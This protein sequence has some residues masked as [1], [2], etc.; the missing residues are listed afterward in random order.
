MP[1]LPE[2]ET[3]VLGLRKKVLKRTFKDVW[4]DFDK[5]VKKPANFKEFKKRL[6]REKIKLAGRSAHFCPYCQKL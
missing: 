2:V 4:T 3:T 5:I 1:E 6:K